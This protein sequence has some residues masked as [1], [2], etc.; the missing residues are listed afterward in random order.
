MVFNILLQGFLW[1]IFWSKVASRCWNPKQNSWCQ[2][3]LIPFS[4]WLNHIERKMEGLSPIM[5]SLEGRWHTYA[6]LGSQTLVLFGFQQ[7]LSKDVYEQFLTCWH[8]LPPQRDYI[9]LCLSLFNHP[10]VVHSI[11]AYEAHVWL[12]VTN[13]QVRVKTTVRS[14][15][16][17]FLL[18]CA[19]VEQADLK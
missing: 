18:R 5:Q 1:Y 4:K 2:H 15:L 11:W 12:M 8:V 3:P 6:V 14:A 7:S 9:Y 17:I 10:A 16:F 19:D 13:K